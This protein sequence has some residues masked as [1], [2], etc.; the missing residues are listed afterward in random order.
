MRGR[1]RLELPIDEMAARY[2]AGESTYELAN[3]YGVSQMTIWHRL[4]DIGFKMRRGGASFGNQNLLGHYKR[5]GPLHITT[6][7]YFRTNDRDGDICWI[8]R[9]CWEAHHGPIPEGHA[10][11]HIDGNRQHNEIDNLLCM[12]K[13]EH[14]ALHNRKRAGKGRTGNGSQ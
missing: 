11:H 6:G 12:S 4:D 10:V 3:V 9:G 7:G 5:G 1:P 13:S 14:A 2:V 8:H